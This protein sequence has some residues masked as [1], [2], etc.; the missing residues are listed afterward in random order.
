MKI[1]FTKCHANG[2]DFILILSEYFPEVDDKESIIQRL[3]NRHTGIG[4]D[5]LFIISPSEKND[6]SL[7]YYNS[8]GSWE[9]F[10]ANGSRCAS[11]FMYQSRKVEQKMTFET[12]AGMYWSEIKSEGMVMMGMRTPEYKSKA[13]NPEGCAGFFVNSGARHFVCESNNLDEEYVT[14][15]GR[16]IR[17]HQIFQPK[18]INVN[19]YKLE[20]DGTIQIR[21]YEKGVEQMMLSCSSGS[22]AVVFHLS[23]S[24]GLSSPITTASPGG[25][26]RFTFDKNWKDASCEGPAEILFSSEFSS[27]HSDYA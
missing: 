16:R 7:D 4:A 15:I 10:C 5:G 22:T 6:F 18:G 11:L 3:C 21:T 8:D 26:L 9:T 20:D 12:G 25:K 17:H 14:N 19:F 13:L 1:P 27:F 2:N 24:L 23:H